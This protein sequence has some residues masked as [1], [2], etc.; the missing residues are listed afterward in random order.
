MSSEFLPSSIVKPVT[1]E[2]ENNSE[3]S[4]LN[5]QFLS[6]KK[7]TSNTLEKH[8]TSFVNDYESWLI[9]QKKIDRLKG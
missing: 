6:S 2:L 8:L 1:L 4:A 3:A 9:R 5:L 7:L